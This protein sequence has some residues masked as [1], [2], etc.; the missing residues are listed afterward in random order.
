[1]IELLGAFIYRWRG[2]PDN[3]HPLPEIIFTSPYALITGLFYWP[4]MEYWSIFP[5]LIV[6]TLTTLGTVTGH[7]RALDMGDTDIGEPERLEFIIRP[8]H[9]R[10]PLY[11]YDL[12]LMSITGLAITLPA[13]M[14]T[15]NPLLAASGAFKG[16]AYALCKWGCKDRHT[17]AGELLTGAVLYAAI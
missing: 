15:L 14:A 5:V 1:M 11:W 10:I 8:L 12:I 7:G 2:S 9:G 17:E 3:P 4:I 6:W 16:A 13:G